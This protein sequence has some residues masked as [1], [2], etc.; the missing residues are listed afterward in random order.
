[1]QLPAAYSKIKEIHI[2]IQFFGECNDQS[3]NNQL[4]QSWKHGQY[5]V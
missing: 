4:S 1:M 2:E 5:V 3:Q